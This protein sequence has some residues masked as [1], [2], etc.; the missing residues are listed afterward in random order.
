MERLERAMATG[1]L[2]V[3]IVLVVVLSIALGA[4][5]YW[6]HHAGQVDAAHRQ[7]AQL[8]LDDELRRTNN[9][10][11]R[12]LRDEDSADPDVLTAVIYRHTGAPLISYDAP[13]HTFRARVA[14]RVEYESRTLFGT[15]EGVIERCLQY[16]YTPGQ[17]HDWTSTMSTVKYDT[18][19]PAVS[20]NSDARIAGQRVAALEASELNRASVRRAL[21]PYRRFLTVGAVTTTGSTVKVSVV[22]SEGTTRQC[23]W[24]TRNGLQILSVPAQ[25]CQR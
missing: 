5:W 3:L 2:S 18:C 6:V 15:S 11:T 22:V 1:F 12:V 24:I 17:D 25:N 8:A 13:R 4:L 20:I 10:T 23:Y 16:T 21:A 19:N 14:K 7:Q 9:E